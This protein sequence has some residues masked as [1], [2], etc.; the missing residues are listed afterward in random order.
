MCLAD[1][2]D[3]FL[4]EGSLIL[5]L[6]RIYKLDTMRCS[7]WHWGST[8]SFGCSLTGAFRRDFEYIMLNHNSQHVAVPPSSLSVHLCAA[9]PAYRPPSLVMCIGCFRDILTTLYVTFF[10][11]ALDFYSV[12]PTIMIF[13][14]FPSY[15]EIVPTVSACAGIPLNFETHSRQ[16]HKSI[17]YLD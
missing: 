15:S 9:Q 14:N 2:L 3:F 8:L 4:R 12:L 7:S 11:N 1:Y 6:P 5:F 10:R 17:Y 16:S 13:M